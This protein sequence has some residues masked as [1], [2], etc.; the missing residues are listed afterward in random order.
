MYKKLLAIFMAALFNINALSASQEADL[1]VK[2]LDTI[3]QESIAAWTAFLKQN[4]WEN[5][6]DKIEPMSSGC[7]LIY[8]I[9]NFLQREN[10][11]FA[12]A[13]MRHLAFSQPH[14]HKKTTE[15][16]ILLAGQAT[17]VVG[18]NEQRY[19]TGDVII[20]PPNFSHYV[21]GKEPCV[22]GVI[23]IPKFTGGDY[24]P[25]EETNTLVHFDKNKFD[26]L[27]AALEVKGL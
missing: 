10:E 19:K 8:P 20:T 24:Y 27:V 2:M 16:Y 13:D 21:I 26:H 15:I 17:V 3:I 5:L 9:P 6:V 7:G 22:I 18:Q 11:S 12:I 4:S 1:S 25:L 14:Y 23:A